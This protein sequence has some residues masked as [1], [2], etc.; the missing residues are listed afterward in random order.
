MI[1][2]LSIK[3]PIQQIANVISTVVNVDVEVINLD[4][5]RVAGTGQ[6]AQNIGRKINSNYVYRK[7]ITDKLDVLLPNLR[8]HEFCLPCPHKDKCR[9]CAELCTPIMLNDDIIGVF[10]LIAF[11]ETQRSVLI[12]HTEDLLAFI[13]Q[14]GSMIVSKIKEEEYINQIRVA[15]DQL[16]VIMNSVNEGILAIDN[17]GKITHVN[18]FAGAMLNHKPQKLLNRPIDEILSD[19]HLFD[20]IT[21][22]EGYNN[23]EIYDFRLKK[24]FL[25]TARPIISHHRIIGA[26]ATFRPLEEVKQLL[27]DYT[28]QRMDVTINTLIGNSEIMADLRRKVLQ[29]AGSTS[30]VLIRGESGTGKELIA[31]AIHSA[32]PRKNKPFIAINCSAIPDA[33]LESELFGYEEG[34]FTG[35]NK[36]GKPGKFEIADG[37]TIFLDE[38]GD[39]PIRLQAKIL[40]TLQEKVVT[41]LGGNNPLNI[42]VRIIAATNQPLEKMI[43]QGEFR[44]DLYYRLNVI[45]I[46]IPPLRERKEDIPPLLE[47]FSKKY[48]K[49]FKKSITGFSGQ[50]LEAIMAYHW[51]GNVRELENTVEYAFNLETTSCILEKSL[52][53]KLREAKLKNKSPAFNTLKEV[54]KNHIKAVLE[55]FGP[56]TEQKKLAAEVLGIG[57]ATL[58]RKIKEYGL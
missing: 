42:D 25:S 7:V 28:E 45:P 41:R 30:T 24:Q 8:E 26:V 29:F 9:E 12:R 13:K 44:E 56:G 40:R 11:D 35:A 57:I 54:E 27:L 46:Y 18:E 14:M 36:R 22:G 31:R 23:K 15:R 49:L 6:Y 33:L 53:F 34:A 48:N 16:L 4:Y 2:L 38:I 32:S 39:M 50:A 17:A 47:H 21:T 51:P 55:S 10:G 58:Y 37:G 3:E 5:V 20:V 52:P 1:D 43:Q 19:S